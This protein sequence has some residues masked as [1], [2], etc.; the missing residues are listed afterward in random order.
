MIKFFIN[1][2]FIKEL[3]DNMLT[4]INFQVALWCGQAF[5]N[6][7]LVLDIDILFQVEDAGRRFLIANGMWDE[8]LFLQ[9]IG[10]EGRA[11]SHI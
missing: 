10:N 6:S 7:K 1:L 3:V 11:V 2:L 5:I 8:P 9:V 4:I